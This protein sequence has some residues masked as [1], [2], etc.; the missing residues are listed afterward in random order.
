MKEKEELESLNGGMVKQNNE[1]MDSLHT[2]EE[3]LETLKRKMTNQ[4]EENSDTRNDCI[5]MIISYLLI[6][7]YHQP[8]RSKYHGMTFTLENFDIC[9]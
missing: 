9:I 5:N 4:T 8:P 6:Q 2:P 3:N 7:E 1:L